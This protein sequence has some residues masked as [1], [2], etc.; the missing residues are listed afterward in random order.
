[1]NINNNVNNV[2]WLASQKGEQVLVVDNYIFSKSGK[3]KTN[4][5]ICYWNCAFF[6]TTG[7]TAKAVTELQ[8]LSDFRGQH[9]HP[10]SESEI[11]DRVLKVCQH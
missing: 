7:C 1:M 10:N 5:N 3:N 6:K 4:P 2:R 8:N 9:D 11:R